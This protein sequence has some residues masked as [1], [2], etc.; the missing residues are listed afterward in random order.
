[1]QWKPD[2][3]VISRKYGY[4]P[5][6]RCW[7]VYLFTTYRP[8]NGSSAKLFTTGDKVAEF[9]TRE[10]ARR[11]TYRLNGWRYKEEKQP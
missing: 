9:L 3:E 10:E 5:C 8:G 1:M 6:G 11:E 4:R 7:A 2:L